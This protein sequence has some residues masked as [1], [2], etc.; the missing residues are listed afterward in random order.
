MCRTFTTW[1]LST[2]KGH[3]VQSGGLGK[4]LDSVSMHG[5]LLSY[6]SQHQPSEPCEL[7]S[8]S[9]LAPSLLQLWDPNNQGTQISIPAASPSKCY[10]RGWKLHWAWLIIFRKYRRKYFPR[11]FGAQHNSDTQIDKDTVRKENCRQYLSWTWN[12]N[13]NKIVANSYMKR[14]TYNHFLVVQRL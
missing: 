9:I 12:R 4:L 1:L 10:F 7:C 6:T 14:M 13:L 5:W 8:L 3:S 2:Q 11:H